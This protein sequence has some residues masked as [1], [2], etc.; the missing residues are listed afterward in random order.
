LEEDKACWSIGCRFQPDQLAVL[1]QLGFLF[2]Q[3]NAEGTR[4]RQIVLYGTDVWAARLR[5]RSTETVVKRLVPP[6][7][8]TPRARLHASRLPEPLSDLDAPTA[9]TVSR[10]ARPVG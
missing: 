5:A 3:M 1:L 10:L 2:A 6:L 9:T 4:L 7:P 8:A